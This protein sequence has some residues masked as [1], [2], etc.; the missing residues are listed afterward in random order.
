MN[1]KLFLLIL[2]FACLISM[3]NK[4]AI[5]QREMPPSP[6]APRTV[7]IP[8]PVERT[9]KNKLRVIVVERK[10][11]P[12]VTA[13]LLVKSGGETDPN[14]L[15]GVANMTAQLLTKGTG[16]RTATQIAEEVESLGGSINANANW[17][18]SGVS[19]TVM[20]DKIDKALEIVA[21]V[22]QNPAFKDDEI[23][24]LREQILDEINLSMSDPGS[25]AGEVAARVAFGDEPYGHPLVGTVESVKKIKRDNLLAA[26]TSF[27]KPENAIL[28]LVGDIKPLKA[29]ALAQKLFGFWKVKKSKQAVPDVISSSSQMAEKR[30]IVVVD[31]PNAGQA[32]VTII[33]KSIKRN[34]SD[35]IASKV[36]NSIFGGGFSSRLNQEVR[37]KRGLSYGAGSAISARRD[38]GSFT[39]RTQTK[40]QSGAEVASLFISELKRLATDPVPTGE[41]TPRKAALI[42]DFGR[43]LERNTELVVQVSELALYGLPLNQINTYIQNVQAITESDIHNFA[44]N[45]LNAENTNIVI[46]GDAKLFLDDLKKAFPNVEV[47]PI[48]ELDLNSASLRK[49]KT[50][51][52]AKTKDKKKRQ[53]ASKS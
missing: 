47:I 3:P 31:M 24:R 30:R 41:L 26:H 29:F 7:S 34:D 53:L 13:R 25:L 20:S 2:S 35:F 4:D 19:V 12:L 32:A 52:G 22:I 38:V 15:S 39:A 6:A 27:Y 28:V 21:D 50:A 1:K 51:G 49:A 16:K 23:E 45:R 5:A 8:T 46:V 37:I 36:V 18:S 42:G 40:N 43:A 10:T 17:D 14:N 33:R 9:L 48:A 44:T 11:L